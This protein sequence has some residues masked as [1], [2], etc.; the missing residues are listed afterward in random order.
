MTEFNPTTPYIQ[1][2]DAPYKVLYEVKID[3]GEAHKEWMKNKIKQENGCYSYKCIHIIRGRTECGK[4]V[5]GTTNYCKVHEQVNKVI[6]DAKDIKDKNDEKNHSYL[7][8]SARLAGLAAKNL[9]K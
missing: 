8:R 7:R 3:F 2:Y 6:K 1:H 5:Y 4:Q 9:Q